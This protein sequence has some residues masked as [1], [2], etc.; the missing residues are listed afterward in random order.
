MENRYR[1]ERSI[2][3]MNLDGK[4]EEY[5]LLK[6]EVLINIKCPLDQTFLM[7]KGLVNGRPWII[8]PKCNLSYDYNGFPKNLQKQY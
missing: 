3:F 7:E 1:K 6:D 2:K 8:C 5:Q 4:E